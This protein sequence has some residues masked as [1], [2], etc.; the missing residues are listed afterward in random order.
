M[1]IDPDFSYLGASPDALVQ[2]KCCG[3]GHLEIT[4]SCYMLH[5]NKDPKE[6]CMD[7]HYHVTLDE[8]EK[9]G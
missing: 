7:D 5:Q 1:F 4:C 9:V 3:K 6:A 2:C 8:N